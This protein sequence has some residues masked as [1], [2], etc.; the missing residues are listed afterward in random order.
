MRQRCA[1]VAQL[2]RLG[3]HP[4]DLTG[5]MSPSATKRR[6]EYA[7]RAVFLDRGHVNTELPDGDYSETD[8]DREPCANGGWTVSGPTFALHSQKCRALR[9]AAVSA[10]AVVLGN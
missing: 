3:E 1:E 4:V 5:V 9:I 10:R 6:G 8:R 2:G 7:D